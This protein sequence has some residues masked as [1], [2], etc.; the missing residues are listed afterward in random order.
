MNLV[1][2]LIQDPTINGNIGGLIGR[3]RSSPRSCHPEL[4]SGSKY[5]LQKK[6]LNN[7][8]KVFCNGLIT[9][10]L[11]HF[12]SPNKQS[13]LLIKYKPLDPILGS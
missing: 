9:T 13:A 10:C 3:K 5:R 12:E 8:D 6:R 2:D 7:Q 11:W 4:D 1:E